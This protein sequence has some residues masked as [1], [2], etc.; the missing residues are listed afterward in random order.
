MRDTL[1]VDPR[2]KRIIHKIAVR[3]KPTLDGNGAVDIEDLEQDLLFRCWGY[4][5]ANSS[6]PSPNFLR[7]WARSSMRSYGYVG[8]NNAVFLKAKLPY[9][10][11]S[12]L[13]EYVVMGR[14]DI[15]AATDEE[16]LDYLRFH[17][18]M[19]REREF[20]LASRERHQSLFWQLV[21]DDHA[22]MSKL[23]DI[24]STGS[25]C[26]WQEL[27]RMWGMSH[28]EQARRFAEGWIR[29]CVESKDEGGAVFHLKE[30]VGRFARRP[31]HYQHDYDW[32]DVN[33]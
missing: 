17:Y 5:R 26:E 10:A 2:L 24:A 27:Q 4:I 11:P 3:W 31:S 9:L 20:E 15:E 8:D 30:S 13:A 12:Q 29:D 23:G 6:M 7:N 22:L 14:D 25:G 16:H 28:R 18:G 33:E 21:S 32:T 1:R 19:Q